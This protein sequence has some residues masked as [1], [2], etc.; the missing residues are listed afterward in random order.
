M[1]QIVH[2]KKLIKKQEKKLS[3]RFLYEI[4]LEEVNF[5]KCLLQSEI[6]IFFK[7]TIETFEDHFEIEEV[8]DQTALKEK[9]WLISILLF[10]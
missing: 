10:S 6:W 9:P 2:L 4:I 3:K 5:S 1:E 7:H 8:L